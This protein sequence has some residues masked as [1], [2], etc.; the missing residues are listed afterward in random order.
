L[1][2]STGLGGLENERE[3]SIPPMRSTKVDW[4]A[5]EAPRLPTQDNASIRNSA[6]SPFPCERSVDDMARLWVLMNTA[7]DARNGCYVAYF[8][9]GRLLFLLPDSRDAA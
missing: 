7:V 6:V 2:F 5:G 4:A 3:V 9:P 1:D 8:I